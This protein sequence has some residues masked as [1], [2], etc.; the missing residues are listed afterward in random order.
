MPK[1]CRDAH[2]FA[3]QLPERQVSNDITP[4]KMAFMNM[5]IAETVLVSVLVPPNN[6]EGSQNVSNVDVIVIGVLNADLMTLVQ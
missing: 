2:T 4:S 1:I 3:A 5:T 6:L